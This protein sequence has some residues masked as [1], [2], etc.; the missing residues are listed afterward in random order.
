MMAMPDR[1]VARM[2]WTIALWLAVSAAVIGE[3]AD[4]DRM[5]VI[6]NMDK[7]QNA[8]RLRC[9]VYQHPP[10]RILY[11]KSEEYGREGNGLRLTFHKVNVGGPY[12]QGGWCGYYTLLFRGERY[13]DA[14]KYTHFTFWIRGE[15]GGER[16][17]WAWP[18]SSWP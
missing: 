1:L 7:V 10:D 2:G 3:E 17:Q 11:S 16:L 14:S 12:G 6:D 8:L 15:N 5:F 18:T 13:F 4:E 9:A